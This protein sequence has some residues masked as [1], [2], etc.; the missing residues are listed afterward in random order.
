MQIYGN[1]AA[2]SVTSD[3]S[4][5][6]VATDQ[7]EIRC[8]RLVIGTNGYTDRLWPGLARSII[9]VASMLIASEPLNDSLA[10]A[11]LPGRQPVAEYAGVPAYYRVDESNRLVLGWRG[12][13]AGTIGS[14]DTRH[15][16]AKVRQLFPAAESLNWTHRWAGMVGITNDQRPRLVRLADNAWAGLGYNGRGIT[17]ATMMGKQLALTLNGLVSGIPLEPLQTVPLHAFCPLGVTARIVSGHFS[18]KRTS[19]L[20]GK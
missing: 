8:K 7:G 19:R 9:P 6:R 11:I 16:E 5:W 1:S 13:L 4:A 17:M 10:S 12:T 2:R 15:L 3:G 20:R 18:D 14:M